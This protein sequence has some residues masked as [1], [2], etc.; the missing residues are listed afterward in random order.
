MTCIFQ[1]SSGA[2]HLLHNSVQIHHRAKP[3]LQIG[4]ERKSRSNLSGILKDTACVRIENH[5]LASQKEVVYFTIIHS[6]SSA[7]EPPVCTTVV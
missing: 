5:L 4:D 3:F 1:D 6:Q 2:A 7:L